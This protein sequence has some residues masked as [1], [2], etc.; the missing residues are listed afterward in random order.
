MDDISVTKTSPGDLGLELARPVYSMYML[1]AFGKLAVAF[2]NMLL[3]RQNSVLSKL[4]FE[5]RQSSVAMNTGI[6]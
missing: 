5:N 3:A 4:I 2:D 1:L 6:R